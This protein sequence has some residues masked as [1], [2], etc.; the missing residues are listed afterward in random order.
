[1][2]KGIDVSSVQSRIDY[3]AVANAGIRFAIVKCGNGNSED[4]VTS[5]RGGPPSELCADPMFGQHV[6][7]FRSVGIP[8]GIYNFGYI[9]LPYGPGYPAGRSPE[10]Q[11][12][13]HW[14]ASEGVGANAGDLPWFLD[15]EWPGPDLWSKWGV[16]KQSA[17]DGCGRYKERYRT[18]SGR[19]GG[20]YTYR[21]FWT[22]IGGPVLN[23]LAACPFWPAQPRATE[24]WPVDGD[25]PTPWAPFAGW[26][27]WQWSPSGGIVVPGIVGRVDG[28]VIADEASL[29]RLLTI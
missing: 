27:V 14:V 26:S 20:I 5:P 9:G 1:M 7:G 29:Q 2:I 11:A 23:D 17:A 6:A 19:V 3:A 15:A 8:V 28:N 10:D 24:A 13:A 12:Q 21:S 18:L 16:T 4:Q 25:S 22:S